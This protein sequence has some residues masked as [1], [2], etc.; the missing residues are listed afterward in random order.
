MRSARQ[1]LHSRALERPAREAAIVEALFDHAP[2]FMGLA[3]HRLRLMP[4]ISSAGRSRPWARAGRSRLAPC[5][6]AAGP[7]R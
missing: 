5:R 1:A 6:V 4:S 3:L 7:S 2:A